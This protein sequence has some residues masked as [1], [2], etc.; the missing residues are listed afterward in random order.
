MNTVIR[1]RMCVVT[2]ATWMVG[3]QSTI[4]MAFQ[5]ID[6]VPFDVNDVTTSHMDASVVIY[7]DDAIFIHL[8]SCGLH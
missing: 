6:D 1:T 7:K 8:E 5:L 2:S 3:L 4:L